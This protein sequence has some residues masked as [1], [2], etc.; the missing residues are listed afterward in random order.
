MA[1][2]PI[3]AMARLGTSPAR[4]VS[5]GL[6]WIGLVILFA[7]GSLADAQDRFPIHIAIH[8]VEDMGPIKAPDRIQGRDGGYSALFKGRSIWIY[9]DTLLSGQDGKGLEILSNSWS[10]TGDLVAANGIDGF[11]DARDQSGSPTPLFPFTA[12]EQVFNQNHLSENCPEPPCSNRWALWPGALVADTARNRVLVFYQKIRVGPG[13]LNFRVAGHS[14][15]VW[16]EM[17]QPARRPFLG[18]Q[19]DD[20]TLMFGPDE[21]GFGSAAVVSDKMLYVFGCDRVGPAM[22]CRLARVP[23]DQALD[24]TAWLYYGTDGTWQTKV[25]ASI[26][27]FDGNDMMSVSFN[28]FLGRFIV[29]YSQPMSTAVMVRTAPAPQGPWSAP[30]EAFEAKKPVSETGWI[31]DALAHP[32]YAREGGRQIFITYSRQ[33]GPESFEQRLVSVRIKRLGPGRR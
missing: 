22:P 18:Q 23:L 21:P 5:I 31:Y 20:Q 25:S 7:T 27:V 12:E 4:A 3:H 1:K 15:A 9:G 24:P 29:V 32:E 11:E 17:T 8:A 16:H 10:W 30:V 13:M 19:Q 33:T 28:P 6:A 26:P 2:K 14:L